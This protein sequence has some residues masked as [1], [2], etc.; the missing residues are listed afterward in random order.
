MPDKREEISSNITDSSKKLNPGNGNS[1]LAEFT[2]DKNQDLTDEK[3]NTETPLQPDITTAF[4]KIEKMNE[5]RVA[6]M[7]DELTSITEATI[8]KIQKMNEERE[9]KVAKSIADMAEIAI[10]KIE[11]INEE[12]EAKRAPAMWEEKLEEWKTL[13]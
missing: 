13:Y 3:N 5:E 12:R 9:A 7:V 8:E 4:D 11:Q 2:K 10:Q 6:K 1:P